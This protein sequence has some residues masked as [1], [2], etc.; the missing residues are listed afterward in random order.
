MFVSGASYLHCVKNRVKPLSVVKQICACIDF[1]GGGIAVVM[2]TLHWC[3]G[4]WGATP[5]CI[6]ARDGSTEVMKLL[7]DAKADFNRPDEEVIRLCA[8]H[9]LLILFCARIRLITLALY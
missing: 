1:Y 5:V 9:P 4:T 2:Y 7:I 8:C 3:C 6:A